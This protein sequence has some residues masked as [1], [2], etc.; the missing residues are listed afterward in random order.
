M[1]NLD[2]VPNALED[3][4]IQIDKKMTGDITNYK[5]IAKTKNSTPANGK[6]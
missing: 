6:F 3:L 2:L 5:I 4:S 1:A